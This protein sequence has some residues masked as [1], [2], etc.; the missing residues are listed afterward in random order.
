[1]TIYD[2]LRQAWHQ[3]QSLVCVGLDPDLDKIPAHIAAKPQPFF[4]FCRRIVDA[5]APH[6]CAFKPQFAH[7]GAVGA[8]GELQQLCEYVRATYPHVLL[9]L[10]AKAGRHRQ[11]RGILRPGSI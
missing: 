10:D 11:Y 1:M 4:E 8:E 7:F 3:Q 2:K 6:V 9:L 5:T